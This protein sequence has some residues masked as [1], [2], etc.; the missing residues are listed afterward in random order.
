MPSE[1][2]AWIKTLPQM[3]LSCSMLH[4]GVFSKATRHLTG[5]WLEYR[6]AL[7]ESAMLATPQQQAVLPL[8][9]CCHMCQT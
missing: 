4:V 6:G 5:C 8:L 3:V 2:A 1:D 7:M 9:G